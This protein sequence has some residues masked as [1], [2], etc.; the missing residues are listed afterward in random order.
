MV[1]SPQSDGFE[2]EWE[3]HP[4]RR[5]R[6]A[7]RD[8]DEEPEVAAPVVDPETDSRMCSRVLSLLRRAVSSISST[9]A[10]LL[11]VRFADGTELRS[12]CHDQYEAWH[13]RGP[14]GFLVV[15][16]PGGGVAIWEP[17]GP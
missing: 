2:Q 4:R 3:D 11:L 12:R 9:A 13:I 17:Q 16:L 10:G 8:R 6:R 15:A 5:L 7:E 14:A 1:E